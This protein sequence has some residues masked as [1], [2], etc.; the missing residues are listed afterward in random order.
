[1]RCRHCEHNVIKPEY[2]PTSV[3]YRIQLCATSHVPEVR[4]VKVDPLKAGQASALILKLSNPT[5]HDM[6][7]TIMDLPTIEDEK[8]MIEEMKKSFQ[9]KNPSSAIKSSLA[10]SLNK[11]QLIEEPRLVKCK[12][13]GNIELPDSSFVV[14]P[15]DDSAEFDDDIQGNQQEPK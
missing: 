5:I 13:T 15:K 8:L 7:I 9:D 4:F 12:I 6:T 11:Q 2:N 14:G 3:K 1:M 10:S